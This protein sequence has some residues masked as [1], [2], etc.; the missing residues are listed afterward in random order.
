MGRRSWNKYHVIAKK[1]DWNSSDLRGIFHACDCGHLPFLYVL[2]KSSFSVS[3][4]KNWGGGGNTTPQNFPLACPLAGG[5]ENHHWK[6]NALSPSSKVFLCFRKHWSFCG[7]QG[8]LNRT[9]SF[10]SNMPQAAVEGQ[11][12]GK[13]LLRHFQVF[14]K[15]LNGYRRKQR[16]VLKEPLTWFNRT[17]LVFFISVSC[18]LAE[19]SFQC[20]S[21]SGSSKFGALP[22]IRVA[23]SV[24]PREYPC[25][26]LSPVL[27]ERHRKTHRTF[28]SYCS[29]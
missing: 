18:D 13:L 2:E 28:R 5:S 17:L 20:Y 25:P 21:G 19:L 10:R 29:R 27:C 9:S 15:H 12:Q 26:A 14:Q 6:S 4:K 8:C 7:L 22:I 11:K 23:V 3:L 24:R 1:N 16:N